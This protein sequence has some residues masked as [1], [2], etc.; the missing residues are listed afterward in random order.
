VRC[1]G[2]LA[3]P[4]LEPWPQMYRLLVAAMAICERG[5]QGEACVSS[6]ASRRGREDEGEKGNA[7]CSRAGASSRAGSSC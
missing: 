5:E 7:P 6:S 4:L 3:S 2:V 1:V